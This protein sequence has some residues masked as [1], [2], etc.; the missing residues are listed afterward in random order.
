[1]RSVILP[2]FPDYEIFEDGS[3]ERVRSVLN[4]AVGPI[5]GRVLNSGYRQFKLVDA[6]GS[7]RA[8]RA[9]RLVCEAFHGAP[10]TDAHHAAH[11]NGDRLDNRASNLAWKTPIENA[12][13]RDAHGTTA[14][15]AKVKNQ[16]GT[17]PLTE[18][19]VAAARASFR[20]ARGDLT[21]LSR[22]YG[23]TRSAMAR[24]LSGEAW[25]HVPCRSALDRSAS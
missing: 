19:R 3:I 13:D 12:T 23:V 4:G 5:V 16:F 25:A 7:R 20:G 21:R 8:V 2:A 9:N 10:P 14:R 1:M 17:S 22:E 18:E 15:G 24:V 11:L 6:V